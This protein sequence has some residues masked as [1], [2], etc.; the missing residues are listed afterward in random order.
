M[1]SG[2]TERG[3]SDPAVG[4]WNVV[5]CEDQLRYAEGLART[6]PIADPAIDVVGIPT[7]VKD[8]LE[9]VAELLPDIVLMDIR[10]PE[11][12]G[13]EGARRIRLVSPGTK[14]V[15]LTV[16]DESEDVIEAIRAGAVGYILKD[17]SAGEIAGLLRA[18]A[19]GHC[20]LP[21]W[22]SD[23]IRRSIEAQPGVSL[24][25]QEEEVLKAVGLGQKQKSIAESLGVSERTV[26]RRVQSLCEKFQVAGLI[27]AA[28][29]AARRT[30]PERGGRGHSR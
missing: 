12:D 7:R 22:A 13:I 1:E 20:V 4:G 23:R 8:C 3:S 27:E 18:V 11:V 29:L 19:E 15:M 30:T 24:T 14:V 25:H 26:R 6:L 2:A 17:R 21:A 9:L 10:L 28:I 16:S 5:I